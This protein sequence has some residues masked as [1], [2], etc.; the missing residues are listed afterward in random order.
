MK[1]SKEIGELA[2]ALAA[3]QG[4]LKHPK[5]S[6]ENPFFKSRYADLSAVWDACR[7]PLSTHGLSVVQTTVPH[8]TGVVIETMLVHVSGQWITGHLVM[9]PKDRGPQAL[10]S[11][12]TYGRRYGLQAIVGVAPEDED[13]DGNAASGRPSK[14]SRPDEV[15]PDAERARWRSS[16]PPAEKTPSPE[17]RARALWTHLLKQTESDAVAAEAIIEECSEEAARDNGEAKRTGSWKALAEDPEWLDATIR[18]Y[19]RK[20]KEAK[21]G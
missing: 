15:D 1:R 20:Y 11:A 14:T 12:I 21:N 9:T 16:K 8:E 17:Q 5:K 13:D 3:A 6:S 7:E 18:L 2:K 19:K 4:E 10:G